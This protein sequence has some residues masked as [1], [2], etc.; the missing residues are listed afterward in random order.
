M[1]NFRDKYIIE[2]KLISFDAYKIEVLRIEQE[3]NPDL[4]KIFLNPYEIKD[5]RFIGLI[6]IKSIN[7]EIYKNGQKVNLVIRT[8][9]NGDNI[10][11]FSTI[12]APFVLKL[13]EVRFYS[14]VRQS[15]ITVK[16]DKEVIVKK[17]SK[18][19]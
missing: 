7:T 13:K 8:H 17:E 14:N 6:K 3:T 1:R 15:I 18:S 4:L 5:G 9:F 11:S 12:D 2:P 16:L 10:I 19:L